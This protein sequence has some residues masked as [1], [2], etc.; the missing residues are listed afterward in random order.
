MS[1][2]CSRCRPDCTVAGFVV[3]LVLGVIT[4][5]LRI[6]GEIS[7]TSAFL[8]VLLGIAVLFLAV[9]LIA[10]AVFREDGCNN[11][12]SVL[13]PFLIGVI[14]T[15][16]LSVLLLAFEFAATSVIGAILTGSL[17]FFFF[18]T[19]TFAACL[20]RCIFNCTE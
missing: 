14:G 7:L 6:T 17:L 2:S 12:C 4:A 3:S 20:T 5:F 1:T 19:V 9:S 8:W 18:L 15:V 13:T 11:L 10:A 16:V